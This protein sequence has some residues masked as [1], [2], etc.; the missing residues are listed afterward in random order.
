MNSPSSRLSKKDKLREKTRVDIEQSKQTTFDNPPETPKKETSEPP[1]HAQKR[2]EIVEVNT[3]IREDE[4]KLKVWF[5]LHPSKTAFSK[6]TAELYFDQLHFHTVPLKIL[7]S[8]LTKD[9]LEFNRVLEMTGIAAGSHTVKV[10]MYELWSSDEKLTS[11]SKEVTVEYV[12]M[13]KEDRHL[14]RVPFVK[15][16]ARADVAIVTEAEKSIYRETEE[17]M[18]KEQTSTRDDW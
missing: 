6:I 8:S 15:S 18:K 10:E 7:P 2:I 4:L 16:E 5:R 11:A 1:A 3:E 12:P 14:I 9:N 17:T 13:R